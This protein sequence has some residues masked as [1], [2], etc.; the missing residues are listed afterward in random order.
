MAGTAGTNEHRDRSGSH[1]R[2]TAVPSGP[3]R[4]SPNTCWVQPPSVRRATPRRDRHKQ[5]AREPRPQPCSHALLNQQKPWTWR[6]FLL[7]TGTLYGFGVWGLRDLQRPVVQH[8]EPE[9][10][11]VVVLLL[12]RERHPNPP[13][14]QF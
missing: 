2:P 14:R 1:S 6:F 10:L 3:C 4:A 13:S 8:R 5:T 12:D 9:P 7:T 11:P